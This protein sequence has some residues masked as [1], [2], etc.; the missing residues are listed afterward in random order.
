M[1]NRVGFHDATIVGHQLDRNVLT[2]TIEDAQ[3]ASSL[4]NV[5]VRI[6]GIHKIVRDDV[7]VTAFSMEGDDAEILTF[8]HDQQPVYLL[9]DWNIYAQRRQSTVK[10][11][12]FCDFVDIEVPVESISHN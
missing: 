3:T 1:T 6:S 5:A 8:K 7:E 9:V 4:S 10:Y 11:E 12:V 2:L